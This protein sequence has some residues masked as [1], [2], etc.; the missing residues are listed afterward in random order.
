M[1]I[2][3]ESDFVVAVPITS[4]SLRMI[5]SDQNPDVAFVSDKITVAQKEDDRRSDTMQHSGSSSDD[6]GLD[7]IE[8]KVASASARRKEREALELLAK[9]S[10]AQGSNS[11]ALSV[12]SVRSLHSVC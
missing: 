6:K 3:S 4:A 1:T 11:S 5:S 12:L 9:P 8:A 10:R 7:V 2:S